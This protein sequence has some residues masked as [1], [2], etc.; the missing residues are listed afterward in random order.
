M[1]IASCTAKCFTLI[2]ALVI[3]IVG[4]VLLGVGAFAATRLADYI[5]IGPTPW[6]LIAIGALVLFLSFAGFGV[7][8][9]PRRRK[10]NL[11]IM[12]ILTL[13][14]FAMSAAATGLGFYYEEIMEKA[15]K[16]GFG[17]QAES[18]G[19]GLNTLEKGFYHGLRDTFQDLYADCEPTSYQSTD[20]HDECVS[21]ENNPNVTVE[22]CAAAEYPVG[23]VGIYC[24]KG[25]GLGSPFTAEKAMEFP[26]PEK[27]LSIDDFVNKRSFSYFAN[28]ACMP[29]TQ[30]YQDADVEMARLAAGG[31]ANTTFGSCYSS[32]WWGAVGNA[33][34]AAG[35]TEQPDGE[36]LTAGQ[37]DFFGQLQSKGAQKMND[38]MIFCF[39]SDLATDSKL[40][41]F[42]KDVSA[43]SKWIA[44]GASFFFLFVFVSE[45]YLCCCYRDTSDRIKGN[46]LTVLRP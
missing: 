12:M 15:F 14:C 41:K 6:I 38:K 27:S 36:P 30:R 11:S 8:C 44:L 1:S 24:K 19:H 17:D 18:A 20:V 46:Q 22:S 28:F 10:C 45:C 4:V 16:Y 13:L 31:E 35:F 43:Y 25:P 2:F 23:R 29:T 40:W 5:P 33:T 42:I 32:N 9:C 7:L 34:R 39:C 3:F 26:S 37:A 21:F